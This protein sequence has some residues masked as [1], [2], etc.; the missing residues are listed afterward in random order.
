MF[1]FAY[2]CIQTSW[3]FT[4]SFMIFN[5]VSNV[6][7]LQKQRN[8]NGLNQALARNNFALNLI[9]NLKTYQD[10]ITWGP[11]YQTISLPAFLILAIGLAVVVEYRS[12]SKGLIEIST[13]SGT[14]L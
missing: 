6:E 2:L 12:G 4:I 5:S 11:K 9:R 10:T 14:A 8:L 7:K 1:Q 3:I 13:R